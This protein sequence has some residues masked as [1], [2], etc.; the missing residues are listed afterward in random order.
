MLVKTK[1]GGQFLNEKNVSVGLSSLARV[2]SV[3]LHFED[4]LLKLWWKQAVHLVG[5]LGAIIDVKVSLDSEPPL[6]R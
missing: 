1:L 6:S 5:K 3:K 4:L 2:E